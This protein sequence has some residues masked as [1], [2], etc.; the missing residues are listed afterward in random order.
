MNGT[1]SGQMVPVAGVWRIWFEHPS[2]GDQVQGDPVDVPANTNPDHVF[3][4]H[5]V[6]SFDGQDIADTSLVPIAN[7]SQTYQAYPAQ[8]AFGA[9]DKLTATISATDTAVTITSGKAGYNYAEFI[10]ELAGQPVVSRDDPTDNGVFV[11]ANVYDLSDPETPVTSDVRRMVF[12]ENT[13]P[14][15]QV[16]ALA[17]GGRMH[18][19]GVPRVNL[20]DV[21][22]LGAVDSVNGALPYEM[23]IV[24]VLPDSSAIR[25][26]AVAA[27]KPQSAKGHKKHPQNQ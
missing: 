8:T 13:K 12:V 17:K 2:P 7:G 25:E 23:I 10:I 15:K 18:V 11:L 22:A 14:A 4:V 21:A 1:S 19:L 20:A 3:E 5:P 24:A 6:T 26:P 27:N 9:Y 16:L